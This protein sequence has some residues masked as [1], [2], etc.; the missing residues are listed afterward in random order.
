MRIEQTGL[1]DCVIIHPPVFRDNRGYFAVIH[2]AEQFKKEIPSANEFVLDNQ[3]KSKKNTVRGLHMQ[4][5]DHAQAKLIRVLKGKILDVVVDARPSSPTYLKHF[6]MEVDAKSF[7]QLYVPRG[8]LH[9]FSVLSEKAVVNYKCDNH[10]EPASEVGVR[11]D[12]DELGIDWRVDAEK[13]IQSDKDK[14]LP[15]LKDFLQSRQS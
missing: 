5:G 6:S 11:Y 4:S 7:A 9:G 1:Q 15:S 14:K 3:S 8:F 12:D 13:V 10:Y 2:N